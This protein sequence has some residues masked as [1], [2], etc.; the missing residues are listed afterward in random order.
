MAL[1]VRGLNSMCLTKDIIRAISSFISLE[2]EEDFVVKLQ[3]E[4][5]PY[6]LKSVL[7][8]SCGGILLNLCG[9]QSYVYDDGEVELVCTR[10]E[11]EKIHNKDI[12]DAIS[13]NNDLL[14]LL[15]QKT[16]SESNIAFK[17]GGYL[18]VPDNI[19]CIFQKEYS[20]YLEE[21][22]VRLHKLLKKITIIEDENN[23]HT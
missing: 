23:D 4:D 17:Q 12:L 22:N 5:T 15:R 14:L 1:E 2:T 6:K 16:L 19:M 18:K 3:D 9:G 13:R 21:E 20:T 7:F 8:H 10:S 11:F